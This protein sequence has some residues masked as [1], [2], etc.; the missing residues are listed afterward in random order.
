MA[1]L[2][3]S[4]FGGAPEDPAWHDTSLRFD[5]P[6]R[7]LDLRAGEALL[8]QQHVRQPGLAH[9]AHIGPCLL[10]TVPGGA[11]LAPAWLLQQDSCNKTAA[12]P[13]PPPPSASTIN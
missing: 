9:T 8:E 5:S 4:L 11:L 2:F 1:E 6:A 7:D 13:P 3:A 10:S 12:R